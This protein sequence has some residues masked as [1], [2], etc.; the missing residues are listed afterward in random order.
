MGYRDNTPIT[1]NQMERKMDIGV[2]IRIMENGSYYSI[3]G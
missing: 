2:Y 1:E 3:F